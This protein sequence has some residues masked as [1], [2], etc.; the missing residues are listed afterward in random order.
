MT[1]IVNRSLRMFIHS[2]FD[3]KLY[4]IR[5]VFIFIH[6]RYLIKNKCVLYKSNINENFINLYIYVFIL[7]IISP[8]HGIRKEKEKKKGKEKY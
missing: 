1:N 6:T 5:N 7:I 8:F 3:V 4:R 2:N